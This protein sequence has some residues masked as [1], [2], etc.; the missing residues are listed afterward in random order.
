[1]NTQVLKNLNIPI[2]E[3]IKKFKEAAKR[4]LPNETLLQHDAS[5]IGI[6]LREDGV[7]EL[8]AGQA[9]ILLDSNTGNIILI[10]TNIL[11]A[12]NTAMTYLDNEKGFIINNHELQ[13]IWYNNEQEVVVP[14]EKASL[15][16]TYLLAGTPAHGGQKSVPLSDLLV[17]KKLFKQAKVQSEID[18]LIGILE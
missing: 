15:T 1:M 13:P 16:K 14:R 9:A 8:F 4:K 6:H 18:S 17:S 12:A 2:D 7:L 3:A 11:T 5:D 10:G